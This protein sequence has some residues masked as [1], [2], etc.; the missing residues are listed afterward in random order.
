[1]RAATTSTSDAST[2]EKRTNSLTLTSTDLDSELARTTKKH[3]LENGQSVMV[4]QNNGQLANG[5][6]LGDPTPV[7]TSD[8][9][10][11]PAKEVNQVLDTE[12]KSCSG[13]DIQYVLPP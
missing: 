12:D 13:I 2:G 10:S 11:Q 5:L 4:K 9:E 1:M 6:G 7:T 8:S 3:R